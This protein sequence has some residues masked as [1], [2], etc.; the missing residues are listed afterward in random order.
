VNGQGQAT[1][2]L[3]PGKELVLNVQEAGWTPESIWK[4][5]KNLAPTG[6]PSPQS[7]PLHLFYSTFFDFVLIIGMD[8]G[9]TDAGR[10]VAATSILSTLGPNIF[11][12][13][14]TK[15]STFTLLVLGISRWLLYVWKICSPLG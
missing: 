11:W 8:Q 4:D 2:V 5:A 1:S 15:L 6:T 14:S 9:C 10:Q 13:M 12:T 3:P 7:S